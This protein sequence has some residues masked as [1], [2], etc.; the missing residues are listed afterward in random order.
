VF[1]AGCATLADEQIVVTV[2]VAM[3]DVTMIGVFVV[4]GSKLVVL[5]YVRFLKNGSQPAVV[6]EGTVVVVKDASGS[7]RARRRL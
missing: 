5:L 6:D 2:T 1:G 3:V 4:V 7:F